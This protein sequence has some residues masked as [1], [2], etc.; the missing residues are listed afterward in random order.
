MAG[1]TDEVGQNA[2][3]VWS[4][5]I[6]PLLAVDEGD[7][8]LQPI[9]VEEPLSHSRTGEMPAPIGRRFLGWTI[10][11]LIAV[12]VM[13][14]MVALGLV[15][16]IQSLPGFAGAIALEAGWKALQLVLHGG[17]GFG[18]ELGEAASREWISLVLPLVLAL[19]AAPF[20]QFVYQTV[21]LAWRGRT[22]GKMATDV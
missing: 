17:H 19:L 10:D 1:R 21:L 4:A 16:L 22:L 5:G 15:L 18:G 7:F 6:R 9:A 12:I 2:D 3:S 8:M 11:F 13:I 20:I 14:G